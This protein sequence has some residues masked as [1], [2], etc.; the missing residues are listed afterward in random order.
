MTKAEMKA[1]AKFLNMPASVLE[2]FFKFIGATVKVSE[3]AANKFHVENDFAYFI[4]LFKND[5]VKHLAEKTANDPS[6][7]IVMTDKERKFFYGE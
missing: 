5:I 1:F 6:L 3:E 2:G 4:P 7:R